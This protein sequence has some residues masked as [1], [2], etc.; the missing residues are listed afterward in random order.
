MR[1]RK[2][3]ARFG[4]ILLSIVMM[5]S[6]LVN[7][8]AAYDAPTFSDVQKLLGLHL[9]RAGGRE[10]LSQGHGRRQVRA[11]R[12]RLISVYLGPFLCFSWE[13]HINDYRQEI[14]KL[15]DVLQ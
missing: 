9:H 7:A 15:A 12:P 1:I 2:I 4:A 6:L 5:L 11:Q 8:F 14:Q 10:G 3:T 13:N